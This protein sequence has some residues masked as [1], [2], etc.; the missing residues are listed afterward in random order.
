M[1][2]PAASPYALASLTEV[3]L[4]LGYQSDDTARDNTVQRAINAASIAVLRRSQRKFVVPEADQTV[5]KP[6][7]VRIRPT[8]VEL[9]YIRVDDMY[10]SP[11]E[12]AFLE[13]NR[14]GPADPQVLNN[15]G[16]DYWLLP[17][18]PEPGMPFE[19]IYFP[20]DASSIFTA[21][22]WLRVKSEHWG[23]AEIPEDMVECVVACAAAFVL[24]DP[25]K[26]SE[27][28]AQ[29]GRRVKIDSIILPEWEDTVDEYRIFRVA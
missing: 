9:G 6:R 7:W 5:D 26:Q 28:A 20:T 27:L 8:D 25:N 3:R 10:D 24:N 13:P 18:F 11:A 16:T 17:D 15:D 2:T 19:Y 4:F 1:T 12:V 22:N 23:F 21:G 29:A 14:N